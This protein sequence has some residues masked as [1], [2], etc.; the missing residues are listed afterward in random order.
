MWQKNAKLGNCNV[1]KESNTPELENASPLQPGRN[2]CTYQMQEK[3]SRTTEARTLSQGLSGKI[4]ALS[5]RNERGEG[6]GTKLNIC[7]DYR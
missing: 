1:F 4:T 2:R 7:L 3:K 6:G 5:L